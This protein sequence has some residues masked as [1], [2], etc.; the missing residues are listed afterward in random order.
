MRALGQ[1]ASYIF[2][3]IDPESVAN[4][5]TES[6]GLDARIVE[7][8][9]TSAISKEARHAHT[10]PK[11]VLVFLDPFLPFERFTPESQTPIELA[12]SLAAAGYR[13]FFWY[14]YDTVEQ[15]GWAREELASLAPGIDF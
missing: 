1:D 8:D 3:D 6:A 9:G 15:R 2:C 13:I 12:A 11:D 14:R 4:L 7:G 10:K 5:R